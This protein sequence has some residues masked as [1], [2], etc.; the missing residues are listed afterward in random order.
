MTALAA[1]SIRETIGGTKR[2][3]GSY[4]VNALSVIYNGS[5][6]SLDATGALVPAADTAATLFVGYVEEGGTGGAADGDLMLDVY[7]A[8][9]KV[10]TGTTAA[11][12]LNVA[13]MVEDSNTVDLAAAT[14]ND[15]ICG[16]I[17]RRESATLAW[18]QLAPTVTL[19]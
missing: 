1:Q 18:I 19:A 14:T 12:D 11:D 16:Y 4:P 13:V 17:V 3:V 10:I 9:A 15:I 5:L 7:V 8:I 2:F 6:V